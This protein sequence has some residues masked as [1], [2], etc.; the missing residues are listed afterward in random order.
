[1]MK[2]SKLTTILVLMLALVMTVS[3]IIAINAADE[4]VPTTDITAHNLSL[5]DEIDILYYVTETNL[6]EG[7]ESGVL[8]WKGPQTEYTY[9]TEDYKLTEVERVDDSGR[10]IYAFD[11]VAAKQACDYFYAV[12]F[13]KNG[14]EVI[15][16]NVE[17]YSILEYC[18]NM[19]DSTA[20][21]EDGQVALSS[22]VS[23]IRAYCAGAQRFFNYSPNGFATENYVRVT[24]NNGTLSDGMTTGLFLPYSNVEMHCEGD[25]VEWLDEV[26]N[27]IGIGNSYTLALGTGEMTVTAS[28]TTVIST[29]EQFAA[30]EA[31][32]RYVLANDITIDSTYS[33]TFSG[34][35]DGDGNTITTSVP[36]FS[37][38]TGTVKNLTIEGNIVNT[39]EGTAVPAAATGAVAQCVPG[40]KT[41]TLANITNNADVSGLYRTGGLIGQVNNGSRVDVVRCVNNGA[42]SGSNMIGGLIGYVQGKTSYITNCVNNG[43]V[44]IVSIGGAARQGLAGGIVGRW[45]GDNLD[46]Y[47]THT[48]LISNCL[49]TGN[50]DAASQAGGILGFLR[51]CVATI[52]YCTNTGFV[53]AAT[54][55]CGG[56]FGGS[57]VTNIT[58]DG[59]TYKN[60]ARSK[61][62]VESCENVGDVTSGG[63]VGG[64]GGYYWADNSG[65]NAKIYNSVNYGA[66]TNTGSGQQVA[67]QILGYSNS[68]KTELKNNIGYGSVACTGTPAN[69]ATPPY[70]VFLAFSSSAIPTSDYISG[71]L[72]IDSDGTEYATFSINTSEAELARRIK[73][74]DIAEGTAVTPDMLKVVDQQTIKAAIDELAGIGYD[75]DQ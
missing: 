7:A 4:A 38:L 48:L 10:K 35:F 16:G 14:E 19:K 25:I 58:K 63:K 18:I 62:T 45:G 69:E 47:L 32:G 26:A 50:I 6:P 44:T 66:V 61:L 70:T 27:V 36:L 2:K 9:G 3:C 42:I 31:G 1:M 64:I 52:E 41:A 59:T 30:M 57:N 22:L 23:S 71:N 72:L 43:D 12:S 60:K 54:S 51:G 13:I 75:P 21:M 65:F 29:A 56:I 33:G 37:K 68:T 55:D 5:T 40:N 34:R 67:S 46:A 39:T 11:K 20:R 73:L 28:V 49:N 74:E 53:T 15:T 24:V 17:K 8:I